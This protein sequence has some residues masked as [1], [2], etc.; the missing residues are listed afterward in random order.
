[1]TSP[2]LSAPLDQGVLSSTPAATVALKAVEPVSTAPA[3][4]RAPRRSTPLTIAMLAVLAYFLLPLFWLL[5]AS[6]KSTQDLFNS[7]GLWFSHAPQL[8]TNIRATF[9]QDD[10]VFAHWLLNTVI[11]AGVSSLGAALLAAAGGYGFAKF[12]FRGDRA[13]FNLVLGAVMVPTTALAIPTYLLFAQAGLVNTPWA[14]ILPSLVNPFGLY[15]MRIYAQDAV[16]DSL[17][18]AARIDGAGE[19]RIFFRIVLRLLGP[20]LVTVLLFTLVATWN[21]YFLP[22]IMLNDPDL[23]PVTVGLSSWAAQAQNGGA[24]SSS[25]MLALV[26]TGS[27]LSIIPLVVA[28]LLLQRYWQSGLA[29]G[30][31]KQ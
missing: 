6:T 11:Y 22:L 4:K 17:L 9:A 12:R 19:A 27:M 23:Y 29:A 3:R 31:V 26:V 1:M 24:G 16:P 25:D 30:G 8:L 18:E 20:G 28:F 21:N 14:V 13:A 2:K 10:G 15:L 5:I 7:F